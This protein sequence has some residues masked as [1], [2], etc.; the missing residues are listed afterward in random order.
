MIMLP[1]DKR[2]RNSTD[3]NKTSLDIIKLL[4][5]AMKILF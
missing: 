2:S 5:F 4:N 1:Y 3:K